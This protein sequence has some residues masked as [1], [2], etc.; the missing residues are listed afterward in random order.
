[1][2]FFNTNSKSKSK[3]DCNGGIST[4]II[5]CVETTRYYDTNFIIFKKN[6]FILSSFY[7][8]KRGNSYVGLDISKF[9]FL[10]ISIIIFELN[11]QVLILELQH[12]FSI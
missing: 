10:E 3:V 5:V 1:M 4:N 11:N 2:Q 12:F 8:Y 7:F 9:F 6:P